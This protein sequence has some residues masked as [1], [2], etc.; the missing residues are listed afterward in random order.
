MERS[1]LNFDA[2]E[3]LRGYGIARMKK[4]IFI[5]VSLFFFLIQQSFAV[6]KIDITRG[7]LEP[8]PIAV[9]NFY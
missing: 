1:A 5:T 6:V 4:I 2:K 9:S 8:L 7:N 3:M